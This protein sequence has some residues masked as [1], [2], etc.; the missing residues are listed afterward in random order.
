MELPKISIVCPVYNEKPMLLLF[1]DTLLPVLKQLHHSYEILFVDDGSRDGTYELLI[2]AREKYDHIRIVRLSRNFGK[3]AAVTAGL[4]HSR[5]EAI[6]PMDVDLQDP[7]SLIPEFIRQWEKGYEVVLGK[8]MD[9]ASDGYCKRI[10]A[11]W[12]YKIHNCIAQV[13]IPENTGDFRLI[14][15]KVLDAIQMLPENQR[16]MKGIFAWVGFEPAVVEYTRCCRRAGKSSF[17][18][19]RLWNL[20]LE[21]ITSFSTVPLRIWLYIGM[22]VA[23]ISFL[24]GSFIVV[25]T[26][27]WG[28]KVPGYASL[29]TTILFL[30]GIQLIGIGVLG[31]YMGRIY[32]ESK[33]RPPYIIDKEQ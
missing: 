32:M 28:V 14:S 20:A 3:E 11:E 8:R 15:R 9:R 21:G 5:G 18:G 31:E 22:I 7:P 1:L 24:Y 6:I 13:E 10:T 2:N 27:F 12:F 30:G 29:V 17:N 19:W 25:L 33:K 4:D 23:F 16:F 26:L